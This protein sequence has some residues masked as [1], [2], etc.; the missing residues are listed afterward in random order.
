MGCGSRLIIS[1]LVVSLAWAIGCLITDDPIG[2]GV[3]FLL[4]FPLGL[5]AFFFG[6]VTI[7]GSRKRSKASEQIKE[8]KESLPITRECEECGAEIA[9]ADKICPKCGVELE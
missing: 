2:W 5:I 1:T 6:I 4:I 8:E 9:E 7:T 3:G